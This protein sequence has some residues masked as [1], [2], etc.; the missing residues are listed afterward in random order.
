MRQIPTKIK[1]KA[2]FSHFLHIALTSVL[3]LLL[4]ILVRLRF[5]ELSIGV[6]LILLSKWRMF[7]VKPRHWPANVRANAVDI[8][9]GL[10]AL[11][12]MVN[13]NSGVLQLF[14]A[15]AYGAWLLLLK[16]QSTDLG[17][18]LQAI[19][20]QAAGL[21][22]LFIAWG[23]AP[24]ASLVIGAW[25]ISYVAARHFFGNFE[26]PLVRFLS[27]VWAYGA[28]AL[29]WV[30]GHW[31]L[32]YGPIAQ[33]ALLL[34]V[35]AFGLGGMYYLEKSDRSSV[36]LRRQI[37]FVLFAVTLIVLTFSDWGD[38]AIK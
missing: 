13:S 24:L 18:S 12:F 7:A 38:K 8:T 25:V 29:V 5:Y 21:T 19:T 34:S 31:L 32:F 3:P 4:L 20:A 28:A 6:T 14:W 16:P 33:P 9:V 1:P 15:V 11:I 35:A 37:V 27:A 26:E 10:S 2:G 23:G 30:L 17:V 22:A 36:V